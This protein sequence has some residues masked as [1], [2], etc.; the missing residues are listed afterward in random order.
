MVQVVK[1]ALLAQMVDLVMLEL[2]ME[3][4]ELLVLLERQYTYQYKG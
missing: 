3:E 1:V 4:M 2:R